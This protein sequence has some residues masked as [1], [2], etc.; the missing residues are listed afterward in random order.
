MK[1]EFIT[2]MFFHSSASVPNQKKKKKKKKAKSKSSTIDSAYLNYE[3]GK[4][5]NKTKS[6]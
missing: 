2:I 6:R 4:Q 3:N 5:N 1:I